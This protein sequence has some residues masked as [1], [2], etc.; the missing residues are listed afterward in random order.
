M[1]GT[2]LQN[3]VPLEPDGSPVPKTPR[4][5]G[6]FDHI[7]FAN[8]TSLDVQDVH[9]HLSGQGG[10]TFDHNFGVV[11]A[12]SYAQ[13]T[14]N[15][16]RGQLQFVDLTIS[17]SNATFTLVKFPIQDQATWHLGRIHAGVT[18]DA[19]GNHPAPHC[20]LVLFPDDPYSGE[21]YVQVVPHDAWT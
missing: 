3:V 21:I 20:T 18:A 11:A 4:P 14:V 16:D 6:F 1:K 17:L 13:Q 10:A 19:A 2:Q 8:A 7:T 15:V 5:P 12:K 9:Y